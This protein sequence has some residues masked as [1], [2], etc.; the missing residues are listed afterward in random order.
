MKIAKI[1]E[2]LSC[3]FKLQVVYR[4]IMFIDLL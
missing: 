4:F 1:E 3:K 2:K